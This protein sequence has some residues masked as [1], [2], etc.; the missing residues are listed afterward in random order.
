MINLENHKWKSFKEEFPDINNSE[1]AASIICY[2][3]YEGEELPYEYEYMTFNLGVSDSGTTLWDP[4]DWNGSMNY[5]KD[6]LPDY[7]YWDYIK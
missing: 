2:W 4:M 6:N 7:E 1:H 3:S 5:T